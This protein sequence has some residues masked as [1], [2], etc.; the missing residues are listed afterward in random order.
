MLFVDFMAYN[1]V[2]KHMSFVYVFAVVHCLI[3][4]VR[5]VGNEWNTF[6]WRSLMSDVPKY[7]LICTDV[8]CR[9]ILSF[10]DDLA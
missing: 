5:V 7:F 2:S 10:P 6:H 4:H 8:N 1:T 9:Y 3:L